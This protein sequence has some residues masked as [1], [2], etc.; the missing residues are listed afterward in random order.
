VQSSLEY[1]E[2]TLIVFLFWMLFACAEHRSNEILPDGYVVYLDETDEA[3]K[4]E[5]ADEIANAMVRGI[6]RYT[7]SSGDVIEVM[8]HTTAATEIDDYKLTVNDELLVDFFE[9]PKMRG[10][11]IIRPDGKI[12]LPRK[13]DMVAAGLKP[14]EL[15]SHIETTFADTFRDPI[16]TV[17]VTKFSSKIIEL[18]EAIQN[19]SRGQA[20]T[21]LV[22]PDGYI[23][24]PLIE[25]IQ[26]KGKTLR[27]LKQKIDKKYQLHFKNLQ[28]SIILEK[29]TGKTVFIF[30]EVSSPGSFQIL[31]PMTVLQAIISRGG[32]KETGALDRVKVMF[33]DKEAKVRLR[34]I[35]LLNVIDKTRI[36]EDML[37]TDN[38]VI[39]VPKTRI[40]QADRWVDQYVRQLF[41]FNGTS[42]GFSYELNQQLDLE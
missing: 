19:T 20:K 37:L 32:A 42:L 28:V 7:I 9:H 21:I 25:G 23:Y 38:T 4:T 2:I 36:D 15:A 18:R 16:V 31:R 26:A 29:V 3:I 22:N 27:E 11:H 10:E 41:L 14:E 17:K 8:Y 12:T 39:F 6:Q 35:N 1:R 24:L 13:G 33:W 34:T 5:I 30:G 40:A